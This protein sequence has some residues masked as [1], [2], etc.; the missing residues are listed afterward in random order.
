MEAGLVKVTAESMKSD[1]GTSGHV[2]LYGIYFDSR[3]SEVKPESE[4]ALPEIAKLLTA[5]PKLKLHVVGH[6]DS[7]DDA[8]R[9]KNRRA[10]LVEQ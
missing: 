2:V 6:T 9:P 4:P 10:E 8:G 7:K 1:I 5:D 3:K